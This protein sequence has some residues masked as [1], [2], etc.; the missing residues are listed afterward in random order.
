MKQLSLREDD[1]DS[2]GGCSIGNTS[3]MSA[4]NAEHQQSLQRAMND[5]LAKLLS[6]V[7][8]ILIIFVGA[9]ITVGDMGRPVN[10]HDHLYS[11]II[12]VVGLVFL[13]F[14]HFDIQKHK[15]LV[16][17]WHNKSNER[18]Q[19]VRSLD[20][21]PTPGIDFDSMS[22]TTTAVFNRGYDP[23]NEDIDDQ[24]KRLLNGY[25]F[26]TGKH[27]GNFYL[28]CGIACNSQR[29]FM[30]LRFYNCFIV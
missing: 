1:R 30:I 21:P 27:A 23:M 24:T 11:I 15:K 29:C 4:S 10:D 12:N 20:S 2:I 14:L 17:K 19:T 25:K 9:M 28:K 18:V 26:V 3:D 6:I 7:Y 5:R 22:V 8:C 16:L 13:G